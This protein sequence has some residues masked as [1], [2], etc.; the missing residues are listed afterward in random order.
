ML[1]VPQ[2]DTADT[3]SRRIIRDS[4]HKPNSL[5]ERERCD[6]AQHFIGQLR[7][8]TGQACLIPHHRWIRH[9]WFNASHFWTPWQ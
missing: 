2:N 5:P 4:A 6:G 3:A 8:Q 7:L 9:T 1:S